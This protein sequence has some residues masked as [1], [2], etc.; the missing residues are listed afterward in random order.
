MLHPS[1]MFL[2]AELHSVTS[3]LNIATCWLNQTALQPNEL[4]APLSFMKFG[5]LEVMLYLNL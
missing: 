1:E 5:S 2:S 4:L 3:W